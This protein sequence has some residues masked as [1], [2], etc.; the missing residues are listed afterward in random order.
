M[1]V[2][3]ERELALWWCSWFTLCLEVVVAFEN[4]QTW[5][6]IPVWGG[7]LGGMMTSATPVCVCVC[8]ITAE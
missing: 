4:Q 1:C 7:G 6:P 8:V 3:S 2:C 5:V